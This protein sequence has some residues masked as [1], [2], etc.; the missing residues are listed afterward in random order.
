MASGADSAAD[1]RLD[2]AVSD[3]AAWRR[4]LKSLGVAL[5]IVLGMVASVPGFLLATEI[6]YAAWGYAFI[7]I[8][9]P[10]GVVACI[11]VMVIG[12]AFS[13][14]LVRARTPAAIQSIAARHEIDQKKLAE[15]A[16]LVA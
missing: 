11:L 1:D 13:R 6:Q 12:A 5:S 16:E 9:I 8:S 4:R 14:R 3:F 15:I 7:I 2:D 10:G